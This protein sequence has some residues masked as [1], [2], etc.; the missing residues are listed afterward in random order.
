MEFCGE[1]TAVL[2]DARP[3]KKARLLIQY[4]K[5][6]QLNKALQ[7]RSQLTNFIIIL[8]DSSRIIVKYLIWRALFSCW[9]FWYRI[10]DRAF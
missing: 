7:I 2:R 4:Q 5:R 1:I 10:S 9:H 6:Q 3:R 8:D